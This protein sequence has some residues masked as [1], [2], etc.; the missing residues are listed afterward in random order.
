MSGGHDH[1][2]SAVGGFVLVEGVR[3]LVEPPAV[4]SGV[5]VVFGV[6]GLLGNAVSILLLTRIQGGKARADAVA[7]LLIG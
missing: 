6:V 2:V 1:G 5:M 3:R 7:S 4:A